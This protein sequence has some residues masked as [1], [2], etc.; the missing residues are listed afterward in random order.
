MSTRADSSRGRLRLEGTPEEHDRL[1]NE[2]AAD[3]SRLMR[4]RGKSVELRGKMDDRQEKLEIA[5]VRCTKWQWKTACGRRVGAVVR[6]PAGLMLIDVPSRQTPYLLEWEHEVDEHLDELW[7][8]VSPL[9]N[10]NCP[11]HGTV[12]VRWNYGGRTWMP[13]H[14]NRNRGTINAFSVGL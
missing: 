10:F 13:K 14:W 5:Q 1:A 9:R 2:M 3:L 11:R 8:E 4:T 6:T 7:E 12:L